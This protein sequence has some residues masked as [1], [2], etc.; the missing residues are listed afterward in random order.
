M[1]DRIW[2][3]M[4]GAERLSRY[5]GYLA[6]RFRRRHRILSVTVALCSFVAAVLLLVN[7]SDWFSAGLFLVVAGGTV[8]GSYA[9]YSKKSAIA[10]NMS[11]QFGGL[12]VSWRQL[13]FKW[14]LSD[15]AD[16]AE[17]LERAGSQI[18]ESEIDI[19]ESLNI[20]CDDEAY[21]KCYAEFSQN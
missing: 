6:T 8:W 4:V 7:V 11:K 18:T 10:E 16:R 13:W 12:A 3:G 2:N 5:Y 19:D 1:T 9:D 14:Y 21:K 17:E 15:V 20:R